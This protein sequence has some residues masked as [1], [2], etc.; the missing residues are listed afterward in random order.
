MSCMRCVALATRQSLHVVL[1]N[2]D[3]LVVLLLK[4]V[5]C[6]VPL[7]PSRPRPERIEDS[8]QPSA[9]VGLGPGADWDWPLPGFGGGVNQS[10]PTGGRPVLCGPPQSNSSAS[11]TGFS[12]P[13]LGPSQPGRSGA[14]GSLVSLP[15]KPVLSHQRLPVLPARWSHQKSTPFGLWLP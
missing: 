8:E 11:F 6:E 12:V 15:S 2:D 7:Q 10:H 13:R 4:I 3:V 9:S 1:C 5:A 14:G